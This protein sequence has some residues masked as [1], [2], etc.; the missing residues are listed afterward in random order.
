[1]KWL[2]AR[3]QVSMVWT[4][5]VTARVQLA[6]ITLSMNTS[7]HVDI[8]LQLM[9]TSDVDSWCWQLMLTVDVDSWCSQLMFTVDVHSWC[10]LLMLYF[11]LCEMSTEFVP[12]HANNRFE[13]STTY[14][15]VIRNNVYTA[16]ESTS[17][18]R[19]ILR[20]LWMVADIHKWNSVVR[21]TANIDWLLNSSYPTQITRRV[22]DISTETEL[23]ITMRTYNGSDVMFL[24]LTC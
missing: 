4:R 22:F 2:F 12:L 23:I 1:M 5:K 18:A 24:H 9:L 6:W 16:S 17:I 19:G 7:K 15:Y 10:S 20:I 8:F 11:W 13:I 3:V 14:P 21:Y